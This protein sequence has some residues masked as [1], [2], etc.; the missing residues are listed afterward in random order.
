[1]LSVC[2]S[3]CVCV[4]GY[5]YIDQKRQ[6]SSSVTFRNVL[7]LYSGELSAGAAGSMN[8]PLS[9]VHDFLINI[10]I[11]Y[12]DISTRSSTVSV[13]SCIF[14]RYPFHSPLI[15]LEGHLENTISVSIHVVY[16]EISGN[17][18]G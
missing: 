12:V 5:D 14:N 13:S 16:L 7:I 18:A 8:D 4:F 1:L 11:K 3:V 15:S 10:Y 2:V 6:S 9:A 17:S